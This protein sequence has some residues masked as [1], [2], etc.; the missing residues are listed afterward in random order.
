VSR[1]LF[2][3][4]PLSAALAEE[5]AA[6]TDY[7]RGSASTAEKGDRAFRFIYAT[8]EHTLQYHFNEPLARIGVGAIT[9]K[10]V[11]VALQLA[12]SG[13]RGP[14]R[15]VLAGMD[16]AQLLRVADEIEFRL[17]PDPHAG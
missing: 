14:L 8:G 6:V 7:L 17:Y 15:R 12:L 11:A 3:A 13:L 1:S 10:T 4:T 5:G 16:D 2:L 9:R